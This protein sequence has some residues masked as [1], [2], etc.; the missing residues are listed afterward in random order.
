WQS[1]TGLRSQNPKAREVTT[2]MNPMTRNFLRGATVSL[3][4]VLALIS[5]QLVDAATIH[6]PAD[7][8]TIQAA[9][10]AASNGDTVQVA[11]GTYTENINFNGK[12]ITV[13]STGGPQVT[14]IN[15]GGVGSVVIFS[16]S[17]GSTSV[18]NGFTITNGVAQFASAFAGGGIH[19]SSASPTITKN[20]ITNNQA[21]NGGGIDVNAGSPLIQGNT[22]TQNTEGG[23]SGGTMGGGIFIQGASNAQIIGNTISNNPYWYQ[24]GGIALD[25]AGSPLI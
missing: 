3:A 1:P 21:C 7:Q 12:A 11:P 15:G 6:V 20:I 18:L 9:I 5:P 23:C 10:N 17:E 19:I 25:A 16:S 13:T 24:G 22:I 2:P 8:P 4:V 14:T